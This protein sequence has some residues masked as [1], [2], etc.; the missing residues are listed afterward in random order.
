MHAQVLHVQSL[1]EWAPLCIG[2]YSQANTLVSHLHLLAGQIAL[3][4]ATM[5]LAT[6]GLWEEVSR[7]RQT[8]RGWV[9]NVRWLSPLGC[10]FN[11]QIS[12]SLRNVGAVLASLRS[13]LREALHVV[14]YVRQDSET[15]G[16]LT[17]PQADV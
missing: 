8:K 1:S 10:L 4:P 11:T 2:P 14:A 7:C 9:W 5:T 16:C 15:G 6:G 13:S 17:D 12:L 3:H